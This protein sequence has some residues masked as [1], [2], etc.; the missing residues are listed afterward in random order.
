[1]S[2][3]IYLVM[4]LE[5]I[6]AAHAHACMC[7]CARTHHHHH[8][9]VLSSQVFFS[10]I[11]LLLSQWWTPP[12]RLQVSACSNLLTMSDV[13]IMAVF[14]TESIDCYP[15]IVTR[16]CFTLLLTILV[17]P[18]ITGMTKR[19]M[20]HIHWILILRFYYYYYYYYALLLAVLV[21][22]LWP[23]NVKLHKAS[24]F[25]DVS[26]KD[27]YVPK[28]AIP[29]LRWLVAGLSPRVHGFMPGSV[30]V[31]FMVDKETLGQIFH[32]VLQLSVVNIIPT[33]LFILVY[34]LGNKQLEAT[35]QRHCLSLSTQTCVID[36]CCLCNYFVHS[37]RTCWVPLQQSL[38]VACKALIVL[39]IFPTIISLYATLIPY[40]GYIAHG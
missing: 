9:F 18:M 16:N 32:W 19:F 6:H 2:T 13:P 33:W 1:V 7:M 15:G 20:F 26:I 36:S 17:A 30:H 40:P 24:V 27:C 11:L 22:L 21:L 37:V 23:N 35:G 38:L 3:P 5:I 31:R 28:T 12:L 14:C 39:T 25:M 34:H 10:L 8:H 4:S 29:R